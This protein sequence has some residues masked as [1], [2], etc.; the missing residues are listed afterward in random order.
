MSAP[1]AN[2]MIWVDSVTTGLNEAI[3]SDDLYFSFCRYSD[4]QQLIVRIFKN[5]PGESFEIKISN[6]PSTAPIGMI[7]D[8]YES[9]SISW[10]TLIWPAGFYNIKLFNAFR[11]FNLNC[12]KELLPKNLVSANYFSEPIW[13]SQFQ[14]YLRNKQMW[15]SQN[16]PHEPDLGHDLLP[17]SINFTE[18]ERKIRSQGLKMIVDSFAAS[19][20][21]TKK[22]PVIKFREMGREG[23]IVYRDGP[24]ELEFPYEFGGGK[25]QLIVNIPTP[26]IWESKTSLKLEERRRTLLWIATAIKKYKAPSWRFEIN[27]NEILFYKSDSF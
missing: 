9:I 27:D 17:D 21:N 15:L 19:A 16:D 26:E 18:A 20:G 22:E 23:I 12:T 10:D 6:I 24:V 25:V 2:S 5:Q 8:L 11:E 3:P 7:T 4:S 1:I 13:P 14:F